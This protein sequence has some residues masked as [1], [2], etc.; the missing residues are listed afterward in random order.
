MHFDGF[1]KELL[2]FL[3]TLRENNNKEWFEAHRH[4]YESLLLE[5]SRAFVVEMGEHLQALVPTVNAIPKINGSLFRIYRD[6]RF[7]KDKTPIKSRIG[8]IFW[9]G[10]GKRMQSS[11]FYLHFS[12]DEL[13]FAV[14]IRNFSQSMRD[15]YREYIKVEQHRKDLHKILTL[16]RKKGYLIPEAHYKRY[17]K[18][19]SHESPFSEL[20][21]LGGIYAFKV[22]KPKV[23]LFSE[24][25]IHKAYEV[26]EDM[27]DLQQW[28]YE[29]TLTYVES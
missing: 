10:S 20:S 9:Q 16:L 14:G 4:E 23:Y 6:I 15:T 8:V 22:F 26:Y 19:F 3:K 2:T 29:M 1:P 24:D 27:F 5:P 7:S 13:F 28:V 17:P 25:L 18:G 21:L 12:P 11:S